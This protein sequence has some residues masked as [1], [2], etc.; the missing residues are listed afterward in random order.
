MNIKRI[1]S[2]VDLDHHTPQRRHLRR[3]CPAVACNLPANLTSFTP[4]TVC[5]MATVSAREWAVS[6]TSLAGRLALAHLTSLRLLTTCPIDLG[7]RH[8]RL[9]GRTHVPPDPQY[10]YRC[11]TSN[12]GTHP[13]GD[14]PHSTRLQILFAGLVFFPAIPHIIAEHRTQTPPPR[15]IH[16]HT[17]SYDAAPSP[18]SEGHGVQPCRRMSSRH[19]P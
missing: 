10:C 4:A 2:A 12:C 19:I 18:A 14:H 9:R 1:Y 3:A 13:H 17:Q 8:S 5:R 7:H 11:A 15:N 6:V 16:A